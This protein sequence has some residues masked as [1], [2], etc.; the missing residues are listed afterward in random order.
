MI[1]KTRTHTQPN[2]LGFYHYP[3]HIGKQAAFEKLRQRMIRDHE[4]QIVF[5][6]ER[7]NSLKALKAPK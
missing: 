6:T 1:V 2:A 4:K 3:R 5:L 7:I